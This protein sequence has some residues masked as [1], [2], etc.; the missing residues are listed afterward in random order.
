MFRILRLDRS[1]VTPEMAALYD[2]AFA[3]RGDVPNIFRVMEPAK[4]GEGGCAE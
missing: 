1:Q 3:Q 2:N 4:P